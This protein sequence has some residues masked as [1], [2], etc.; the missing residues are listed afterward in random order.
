MYIV[1]VILQNT[2]VLL[3]F[4]REDACGD[5]LRIQ[6]IITRINHMGVI[7]AD[8]GSK[9]LIIIAQRRKT[10]HKNYINPSRVRI[11]FVPSFASLAKC[12]ETSFLKRVQFQQ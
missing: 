2:K 12:D 3:K 7:G 9:L 1:Q 4:T 6:S 11:G 10:R 5:R 8:C